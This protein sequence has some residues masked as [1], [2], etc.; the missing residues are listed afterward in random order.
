MTA[1]ILAITSPGENRLHNIIVRTDI[2][3]E[4]AVGVFILGGDHQN[5]NAGYPPN[6][7]AD[8]QPV[9]ARQHD[10]QQDECGLRRVKQG[11]S[12]LPR[13]R[14]EQCPALFIDVLC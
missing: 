7:P 9:Y 8:L 6:T 14:G 12:F 10:I 13:F 4:D 5:R 2:Q 3:S 1:R 11:Q